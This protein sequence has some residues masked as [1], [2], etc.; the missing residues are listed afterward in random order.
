MTREDAVKL[1]T[2]YMLSKDWEGNED[3]L[4]AFGMAVEALAQECVLDKVEK[5]INFEE[6]WLRVAG[7][8]AYNVDVAFTSIKHT[9]REGV[10]DHD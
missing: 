10:I 2:T 5:T 7:Y 8:N 9:L 1:L 4:T 6:Q 3:T